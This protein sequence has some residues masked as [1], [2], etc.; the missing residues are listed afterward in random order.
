[1]LVS[2]A[3]FCVVC[4]VFFVMFMSRCFKLEQDYNEYKS[5]PLVLSTGLIN[6]LMLE[7]GLNTDSVQLLVEYPPSWGSIDVNWV[8]KDTDT[9]ANE[10]C[11]IL[12]VDTMPDTSKI[13]FKK[14]M[15]KW[16]QNDYHLLEFDLGK[17]ELAVYLC[18]NAPD[19]S[20]MDNVNDLYDDLLRRKF[21]GKSKTKYYVMMGMH[22]TGERYIDILYKKYQKLCEDYKGTNVLSKDV[23]RDSLVDGEFRPNHTGVWDS[24]VAHTSNKGGEVIILENT[25]VQ[26]NIEQKKPSNVHVQTINTK[27]YLHLRAYTLVKIKTKVNN[28]NRENRGDIV[29]NNNQ[30][31]F[32]DQLQSQSPKYDILWDSADYEN[33]NIKPVIQRKAGW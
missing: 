17:V 13:Y 12:V 8:N 10:Q 29:F 25:S 7:H 3:F 16:L 9:N 28:K 31:K 5:R 26:E 32:F 23:F 20:V 30:K 24:I 4:A 6:Y 1:M 22:G 21:F 18:T 2:L 11:P 27:E 15:T 33:G 14:Q 19:T